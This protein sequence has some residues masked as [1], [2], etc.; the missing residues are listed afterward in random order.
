MA[1][2]SPRQEAD[3]QSIDDGVMG[4]ISQSTF[5][6]LSEHIAKFSGTVS[7]ANNGGF[8]SVRTG[9]DR[10]DLSVCSGFKIRVKGDG[11]TYSFRV[12]Q[13]NNFDGVAYQIKFDT[14]KNEWVEIDLP[15]DRFEATYRG[16]MLSDA[17]PL[18]PNQIRQI[19]FLISDKQAGRFELLIDW[20]KTVMTSEISPA[21]DLRN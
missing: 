16:R 5:R 7:L 19:G 13:D 4:G 21:R 1:F 12:R 20:V 2:K 18:E 17:K 6:I 14:L 15:F 9:L 8:A 3:W 10:I 11:K